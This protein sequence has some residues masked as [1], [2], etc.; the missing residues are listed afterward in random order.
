MIRN[1]VL[2]P[3][4]VRAAFEARGEIFTVPTEKGDYRNL[5]QSAGAIVHPSGL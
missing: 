2:S 5:T 4:G 1:Y 3:T